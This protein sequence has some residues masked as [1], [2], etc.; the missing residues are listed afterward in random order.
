MT[1]SYTAANELLNSWFRAS[2]GT[3]KLVLYQGALAR[4][5]A[6]CTPI[7]TDGTKGY[8]DQNITSSHCSAAASGASE[9]DLAAVTFG[10]ATADWTGATGIALVRQSDDAV[11]IFDDFPATKTVLTGESLVFGVGDI[12]ASEE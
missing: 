6:S 11:V 5:D 8:A 10:P 9:N 12:D 1:K 7:E 2:A 3:Y 4:S